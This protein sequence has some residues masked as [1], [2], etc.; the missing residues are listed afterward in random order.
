MTEVVGNRRYYR[1]NRE[2]RE[3]N[4]AE[5]HARKANAAEARRTVGNSLSREQEAPI[6]AAIYWERW[7][8]ALTSADVEHLIGLTAGWKSLS[9]LWA[10]LGECE[11]PPTLDEAVQI[12]RDARR[13]PVAGEGQ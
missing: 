9:P 8:V 13:R 4:E 6:A 5:H 12:A 11:Q 1:R 3:I 2:T 7:Q 10:V